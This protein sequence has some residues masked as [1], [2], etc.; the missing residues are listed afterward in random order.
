M[1]FF[2][3]KPNKLGWQWTGLPNTVFA[4]Y[5]SKLKMKYS[6]CWTAIA[7]C[8][9]CMCLCCVS[10]DPRATARRIHRNVGEKAACGDDN[11]IIIKGGVQ[12][13]V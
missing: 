12:Y 13:Y 7:V 10:E 4:P 3:G 11:I 1:P 5:L 8:I 9:V 2:G 6:L